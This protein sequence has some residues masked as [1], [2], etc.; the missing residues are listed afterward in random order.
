MM[1]VRQGLIE[2]SCLKEILA[3]HV[4]GRFDASLIWGV[5]CKQSFRWRIKSTRVWVQS[6]VAPVVPTVFACT[7]PL[8]KKNNLCLQADDERIAS[9]VPVG[10]H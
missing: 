6:T 9:D 8:F 7:V 2:L 10:G 1:G 5:L 4:N 3:R